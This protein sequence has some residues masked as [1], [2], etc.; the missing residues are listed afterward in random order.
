MLIQCTKKLLDE[1]YEKPDSDVDQASSLFSW[2]ANVITINRRK[3]VVVVNDNNRYVVVLYGLKAK[4]FR[5]LNELIV[6]AIRQTFREE[7]IKDDVIE[8]YLET[9]GTIIFSKTKNRTTVTRLNKA[10]E[11]VQAFDDL[12]QHDSFHQ[13]EEGIRVSRL[14]VTDGGNGYIYPNEE[15]YKDLEK[16]VGRTDH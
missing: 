1:L 5:K 3:A 10:C 6:H 4:D 12:L 14:L 9:A 11:T 13:I 7:G 16:F 8:Q 15:M 2:H